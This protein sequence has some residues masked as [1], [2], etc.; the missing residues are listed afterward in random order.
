[1]KHPGLRKRI[2][3]GVLLVG[4]STL[5]AFALSE[6]H[7]AVLRFFA[8]IAGITVFGWSLWYGVFRCD[9]CAASPTGCCD[10]HPPEDIF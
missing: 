9:D 7:E 4:Y 3:R 1:M 10:A 8:V 6:D 5:L 2:A